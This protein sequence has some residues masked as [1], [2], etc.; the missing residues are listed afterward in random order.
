MAAGGEHGS[1]AVMAALIGNLGI[2]IAKF[3]GFAV[4]Q[5]SAMLAEAIHSSADSG[6]QALLL[7]GGR[8]SRKEATEEHQFG[9]G[10][11]RYF[12]SFV[13]ALIL[14]ALGSA[15]A[16]FEGIEKI[17]HPHEL[18]NVMVALAIL[19]FAI[20]LEGWSFRT[21]VME[22]IPL[23]GD[24]SWWQFIRRS[25]TPELPVVLLEDFGAMAGL[26]IAFSAILISKVTGDPVWD[27]IGTLIIGLLLGVIAI[28]L[29]I[30][31][32][33]LL[34]GEGAR[35]GDMTKIV[36]AITET[37]YVDHLI[38]IKTQHLGP[39]ELLVGAK[40]AFDPSLTVADLASAIDRVEA[41]IRAKVPYA[42]PIYIEPDLLR[43]VARAA[44]ED[45]V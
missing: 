13:V 7:L 25:R 22:S 19:G 4:T 14:F 17:R 45:P 1:K 34:I 42:T 11:E 5:S 23:K 40:V 28:I 18:D 3:I 33:S 10:R 30:E 26:T 35:R 16:V 44:A 39:E 12:W 41:A 20:C 36:A 8:R 31:M 32:R 37:Q 2:A 27:G 43:D 29:V 24:L 9:Y 15:F 6:N 21:A 38:H